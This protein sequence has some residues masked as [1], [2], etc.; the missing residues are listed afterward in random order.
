MG[1]LDERITKVID[2]YNGVSRKGIRRDPE[3]AH[4][5]ED[6]LLWDFIIDLAQRGNTDAQKLRIIHETERD[7][8][9]A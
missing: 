7:R 4:I 9:Y 6:N 5:Y 8:W 3:L 1:N 2:T